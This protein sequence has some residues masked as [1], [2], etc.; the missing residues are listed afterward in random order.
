MKND[1]EVNEGKDLNLFLNDN[2]VCDLQT[3]STISLNYWEHAVKSETNLQ[4]CENLTPWIRED[5][6]SLIFNNISDNIY[7]L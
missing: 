1:D 5:D 3:K 6:Q 2:N 4:L 7:S